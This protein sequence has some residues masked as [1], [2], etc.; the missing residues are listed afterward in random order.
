MKSPLEMV[1]SALR[2]LNAD[3]TDTTRAGAAN[4]RSGPAALRQ[5]GADR[6]SE[7]ERG[8]V[9]LGGPARPDQ[10]RDG[11]RPPAR[12]PAS[13]STPAH[14]AE[15]WRRARRAAAA[16]A[17]R[18]RPPRWRRSSSGAEGDAA[19]AGD[20][21]RRRSSPH[22][23]FRRGSHAR[24]DARFFARPGWPLAPSAPRPAWLLRAAAQGSS[25]AQDPRRDLPA[26]RRRRPEHRRAVLREA[27]LPAASEHRRRRA[28]QR[29][30]RRASI[31]T[32]ASRCIQRCS[33]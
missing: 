29:A 23:I 30:E 3:V 11:A 12:S 15:R 13:R 1:V 4:R 31:S 28:R 27:V 20:P 16:A 19:G 18:R 17:P 7:H 25:D 8:V 10:L 14:A 9:E 32:A 26:R 5:G 24:R 6:L 2:A 33:R 22:P 21:C